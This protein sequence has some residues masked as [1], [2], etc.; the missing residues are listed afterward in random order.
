[1]LVDKEASRE[2]RRGIRRI[3]I[4]EWDPI[5]VKDTPE[6]ADE[7][8]LYIGDIFELLERGGSVAKISDYLRNIEV[9]RMGMIDAA[10]EPL[11]AEARRGATVS[12][13]TDLRGYF[14]RPS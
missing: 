5:G 2:V 8:D 13:L 7:Y 11:L 1:M 6:A 10:G 12:S 3:L 14:A 4:E 9:D